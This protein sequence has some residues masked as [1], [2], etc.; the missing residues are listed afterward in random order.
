VAGLAIRYFL[1]Q[2]LASINLIGLDT[3]SSSTEDYRQ[4][5]R[6]SSHFEDTSRSFIEL[7][8]EHVLFQSSGAMDNIVADGHLTN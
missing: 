2:I 4:N 8:A 6:G 5:I 7:I 3:N 1:C